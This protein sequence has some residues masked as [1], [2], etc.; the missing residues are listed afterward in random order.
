[1]NNWFKNKRYKESL[2]RVRL[3]WNWSQYIYRP[4]YRVMAFSYWRTMEVNKDRHSPSAPND[5]DVDLLFKQICF[6]GLSVEILKKNTIGKLIKFWFEK[7]RLIIFNIQSN[8]FSDLSKSS[9]S[10]EFH[11]LY[12]GIQFVEMEWLIAYHIPHFSQYFHQNWH[13]LAHLPY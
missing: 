9:I 8:R 6:S 5:N 2:V 7:I 13:A 1:M 10:I 12:L 11:P 4:D 3:I